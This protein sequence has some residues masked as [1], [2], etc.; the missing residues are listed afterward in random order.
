MEFDEYGHL[1]PYEIQE[2]TLNEFHYFFVKKLGNN[3]HRTQL[4]EQYLRFNKH[5]INGL[6]E[7]L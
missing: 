4:Y 5:F 2:I 1:M 6:M 7:V 3:A